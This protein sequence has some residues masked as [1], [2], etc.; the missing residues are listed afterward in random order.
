M[1]YYPFH[2]GDYVSATRHLSWEEDAAYRRL[3]DTYYTMEKPLPAEWRAC[4]R[5]VLAQTDGQR[6]AV[7]TVLNEFF[8]LGPDGWRNSRADAEILA[9]QE[10]QQ[11]QRDKANKRWDMQRAERGIAPALPQHGKKDATASKI[12]ANAMPPTPTPTPIT[13]I[14]PTLD[15]ERFWQAWPKSERKG[16]KTKCLAE[17]LKAG[18]NGHA[19]V[20]IAHVEMMKA[21]RAWTDKGGAYIPAPLVYLHSKAWDGAEKPE[22]IESRPSRE[23][24]PTVFHA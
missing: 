17:W 24:D 14:V 23:Y 21:S 11:I 6:E 3:L 8:E 22:R 5:L 12:D 19:D 2:I 1:N 10:R 13:P 9:M 16:A 15:F 4:C 20:V 18:I 7:Q